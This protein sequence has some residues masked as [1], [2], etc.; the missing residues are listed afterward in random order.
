MSDAQVAEKYS[1][2]A[3][4]TKFLWA[5]SAQKKTF[6]TMSTC[7]ADRFHARENIENA[8]Q[9]AP[10]R[11]K[12]FQDEVAKLVAVIEKAVTPFVISMETQVLSVEAKNKN[13]QRE[14]TAVERNFRNAA[15]NSGS[16]V[17]GVISDLGVQDVAG[18]E[19]EQ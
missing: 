17:K 10:P 1:G 9:K 7:M 3:L 5:L 19:L 16:K 8:I 12:V 2:I 15:S 18:T 14:Y 4:P 6:R 13:V 11:V